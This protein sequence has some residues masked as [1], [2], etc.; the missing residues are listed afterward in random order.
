MKNATTPPLGVSGQGGRSRSDEHELSQ[1]SHGWTMPTGSTAAAQAGQA[2][3]TT[4]RSSSGHQCG[5]VPQ[6]HRL[7]M[8]ATAQRFSQMEN[9]L[10]D[11][12]PLATLRA[13]GTDSRH[14]AQ[15]LA[16]Q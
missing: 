11:L 9:R 7:P 1:R 10:H 14:P 6:P 8:A 5:L 16:A 15:T 12:P 13:V 2:W 3:S 4:D